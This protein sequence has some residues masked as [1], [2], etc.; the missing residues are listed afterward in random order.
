MWFIGCFV[1]KDVI[2]N[3]MY[4]RQYGIGLDANLA[5]SSFKQGKKRCCQQIPR[6]SYLGESKN[7]DSSRK[8]QGEAGNNDKPSKSCCFKANHGINGDDQK[9]AA[10]EAEMDPRNWSCKKT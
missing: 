7:G 10:Q 4:H 8:W 2:G 1:F 6:I 3:G 5:M 9:P